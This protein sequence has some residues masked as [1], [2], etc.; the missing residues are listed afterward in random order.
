[1]RLSILGCGGQGAANSWV[2]V[3]GYEEHSSGAGASGWAL[4]APGLHAKRVD[5]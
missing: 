5:I 3:E 1:M 4:L 2:R